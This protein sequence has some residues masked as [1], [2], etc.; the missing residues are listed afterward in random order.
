MGRP[1]ARAR[2]YDTVPGFVQQAPPAVLGLSGRLHSGTRIAPGFRPSTAEGRCSSGDSDPQESNR[3]IRAELR[4]CSQTPLPTEPCSEMPFRSCRGVRFRS[5]RG[6]SSGN[7]RHRQGSGRCGARPGPEKLG[8]IGILL[9]FDRGASDGVPPS[10]GSTPSHSRHIRGSKSVSPIS[11]EAE[12]GAA[13][14][15]T[16]GRIA[17]VARAGGHCL[18]SVVRVVQAAFRHVEL[19]TGCNGSGR[20]P[21]RWLDRMSAERG[22]LVRTRIGLLHHG[23]AF[24]SH[25]SLFTV[26]ILDHAPR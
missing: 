11:T 9:S 7:P 1:R 2:V 15:A 20:G 10:R 14:R 13:T 25:C 16:T 6:S 12:V 5:R 23:L 22:Q 18:H 8:V 19:A 26:W 4:R 3:W 21:D 24:R 17:R